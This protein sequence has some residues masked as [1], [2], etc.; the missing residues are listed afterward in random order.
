MEK[1][2]AMFVLPSVGGGIEIYRPEDKLDSYSNP[3]STPLH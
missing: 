2:A 3:Y 1:D